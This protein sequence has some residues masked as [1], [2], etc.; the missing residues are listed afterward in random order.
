MAD[1]VATVAKEMAHGGW[2]GGQ[3]QGVTE[4]QKEGGER[5]RGWIEG[6]R[7]RRREGQRD[8]GREPW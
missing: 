6:R 5:E 1:P 3:G 4:R 7:D 2:R 8:G